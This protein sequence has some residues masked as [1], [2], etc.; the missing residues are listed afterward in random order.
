[1]RTFMPVNLSSGRFV[2]QYDI[3]TN[4][5]YIP[6]D[7]TLSTVYTTNKW[8]QFQAKGTF[9]LATGLTNANFSYTG[10]YQ[11]LV[12][13]ARG[14]TDVREA[15]YTWVPSSFG[16]QS[17]GSYVS[18][19]FNALVATN[20]AN[21]PWPEKWPHYRRFEVAQ[22]QIMLNYK[23]D[24]TQ[25]QTAIKTESL[26][27]MEVKD[28]V[29]PSIYLPR[30]DRSIPMEQGY[31][32]GDIKVTL[33]LGDMQKYRASYVAAYLWLEMNEHVTRLNW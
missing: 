8:M 1:V 9:P 7:G 12:T 30:S 25:L 29:Y 31:G 17:F 21:I 33:P 14:V 6:V 18:V 3:K 27:G 15:E 13:D 32:E 11:Y 5:V 23:H 16:F 10:T 22:M 19:Y 2:I 20:D 4:S 26:T 24:L 28:Y